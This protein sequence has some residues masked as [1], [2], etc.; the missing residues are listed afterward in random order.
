VLAFLADFPFEAPETGSVTVGALA[1]LDEP[2]ATAWGFS[3]IVSLKF[4]TSR[5]L[6]SRQSMKSVIWSVGMGTVAV[7]GIGRTY[8]R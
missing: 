4:T 7:Y 8:G 1:W 2:A 3:A 5:F 6:N